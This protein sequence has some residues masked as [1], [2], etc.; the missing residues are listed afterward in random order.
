MFEGKPPNRRRVRETDH[1]RRT[2]DELLAIS[3]NDLVARLESA[4]ELR[5]SLAETPPITKAS[6]DEN[7]AQHLAERNHARPEGNEGRVNPETSAYGKRDGGTQR[8]GAGGTRS[9]IRSRTRGMV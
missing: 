7:S 1:V 3:W 8:G 9:G 6:F 4:R 2:D 5:A